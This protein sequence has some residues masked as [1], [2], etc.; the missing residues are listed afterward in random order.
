[1]SHVDDAQVRQAEICR[2]MTPAQR[3]QQALE[4]NALMRALMDAGLRARNPALGEEERQRVVAERI[5]HARTG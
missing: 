4:L 3:L 2:A 1:M 5:L